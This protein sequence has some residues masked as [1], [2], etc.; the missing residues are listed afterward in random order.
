M[1]IAA[2]RSCARPAAAGVRAGD[3]RPAQLSL[4]Q[5]ACLVQLH[6]ERGAVALQQAGRLAAER[7]VDQLLLDGLLSLVVCL[8]GVVQ[9]ESLLGLQRLA[10]GIILCSNSNH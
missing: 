8:F 1:R 9:L 2:P 5:R 10:L 4:R 6:G 3:L 7:D